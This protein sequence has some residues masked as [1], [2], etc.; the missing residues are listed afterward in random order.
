MR[1]ANLHSELPGEIYKLIHN[2][3]KMLGVPDEYRS[4]LLEMLEIRDD[5]RLVLALTEYLCNHEGEEQAEI[6]LLERIRISPSVSGL[7]R[8]IQIRLSK[9]GTPSNNDLRLLEQLIGGIADDN[10]G[11]ECRQC[12]FHGK[13]MHWQCPGCRSWN[14]TQAR[15]HEGVIAYDVEAA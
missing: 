15:V 10:S 5:V 2:S 4:F 9:H 13:V 12:G 3:Y 6:F 11:Y 7:H 8:L 14:T 1:G